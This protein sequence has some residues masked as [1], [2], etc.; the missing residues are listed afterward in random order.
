[1]SLSTYHCKHGLPSTPS[2]GINSDFSATKGFR[3]IHLYVKLING[4]DMY[5]DNNDQLLK[6]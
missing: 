1:M 4:T 2:L 6:W 5:Y 3:N